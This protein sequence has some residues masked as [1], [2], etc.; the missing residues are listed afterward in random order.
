M[1]RRSD[2]EGVL[3]SEYQRRVNAMLAASH[4]ENERGWRIPN[5]VIEGWEALNQAMWWLRYRL[6]IL[7]PSPYVRAD[8]MRLIRIYL[9]ESRSCP[10]PR[11][12]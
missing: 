1:S 3:R 11:L 8:V 2:R 5:T 10:A 6:L 7:S 9:A 4:V 12:P